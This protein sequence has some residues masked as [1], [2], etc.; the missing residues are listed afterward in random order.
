[1]E[2]KV[3]TSGRIPD[4]IDKCVPHPAKSTPCTDGRHSSINSIRFY[5]IPSQTITR[6]LQKLCVK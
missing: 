5:D 4:S 6:L 1:M 2:R 3:D